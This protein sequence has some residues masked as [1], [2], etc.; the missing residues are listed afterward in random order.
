MTIAKRLKTRLSEKQNPIK[1]GAG[2]TDNCTAVVF[3]TSTA[4]KAVDT[5]VNTFRRRSLLA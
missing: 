5:E 3:V 1:S 2:F 4:E